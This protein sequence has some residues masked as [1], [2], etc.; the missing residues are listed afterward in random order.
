MTQESFETGGRIVGGKLTLEGRVVFEQTLAR[1]A[2][3][4]VTIRITVGKKSRSIAQNR[5]WHGIVIPLFAEHCGYDFEEMKDALALHLIP[6]EVTDLTTGAV[7]VVP[8]H[9]SMLTVAGF[10]DLIDR[11]Q[12]LGAEMNIYIPDPNEVAA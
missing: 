6:R 1:F 9:T 8:G 12:R 2:D 5:Y 10:N 11:A 3:G 7:R 4:P